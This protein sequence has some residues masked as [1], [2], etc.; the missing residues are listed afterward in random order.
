MISAPALV[1][2]ATSCSPINV[3]VGQQLSTCTD[4]TS[5]R[6]VKIFMPPGHSS[7]ADLPDVA[8]M[9]RDSQGWLGQSAWGTAGRFPCPDADA[10][11]ET[12]QQNTHIRDL[13]EICYQWH[14]WH[15]RR[16]R[17]RAELIRHGHAVA[18]CSLEE[19]QTGRVLEVPLWML[20]V[21]ICS[22]TRMAKPGF[23]SAQSLRELRETLQSAQQR[24]QPDSMPE[25]QH[26]FVHIGNAIVQRI[27]HIAVGL[28]RS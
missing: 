10:R 23:A 7:G 18:Y 8:C 25:R 11:H 19:V 4:R 17:V 27:S 21:A 12:R 15:G 3:S 2:S 1:R 13:R 20:D 24:P 6:W 26:R 16:V 22:R 14:P 9:R 5:G 28:W